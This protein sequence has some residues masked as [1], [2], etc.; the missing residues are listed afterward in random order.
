MK[1]GVLHRDISNGNILILVDQDAEI[2]PKQGLLIDWDLAKYKEDLGQ[3]ATQ[4]GRSVSA[5]H[6]CSH[7]LIKN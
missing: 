5:L 3:G 1:A 4:H 6:A 2:T 7:L